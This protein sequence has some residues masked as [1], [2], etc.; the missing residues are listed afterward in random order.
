MIK[1]SKNRDF[2]IAKIKVV[3]VG[4]AGG[5]AVSRM[6]G[7]F[8]RGVDFIAV[9]TDVQDLNFCRTRKKIYIGKNTTKGLGAGMNPD[10][11][12]QAAEENRAELAEALK[13]ADMVFITAGF[14]GGTGT[15]AAPIIAELTRDLG[16]LTVAVITKPFGFEGAQRV[17]IAQEGLL[18]LQDN[19]DTLI[20]IPNDKIFSIIDKNTPLNKAFGKIDEVLKNAV[21][22]IAELITAPGIINVDFADVK[23]VMQDS[24]SA[25]IGIGVA[26]G[27]ERAA[28]A[29]KMAI[30][31]PLLE[32]SVD[33]AT[34]V[35]FSVSGHRDLKMTEVN[36]VAQLIAE[37]VDRS[38]KIIFGTYNDRNLNKGAIK[39]T[40]VATGFENSLNREIGLL[41]DLFI[42]YPPKSESKAV[43]GSTSLT[44]NPEYRRRVE[45]S[46]TKE[47]KKRLPS[48]IK[49]KR[50]PTLAEGEV[51]V[52][53][54]K[55]VGRKDDEDI[56]DVPTFLRRKR[57]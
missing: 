14:G 38:A 48:N 16:I 11:G 44:I 36:E 53:T 28:N 25:I 39:V 13:G 26:E 6:C 29:A 10:L 12:R 3:G 22:G 27:E 4:G 9:N 37:N 18:K 52:P 24:G 21:M 5:N 34:G 40:L 45:F 57:R 23:T 7:D 30:N 17:R 49:A 50:A 54:A 32:I 33:G 1:K 46:E 56:W 43:D 41:P 31:S 55:R 15:G 35:L 51:G 2:N 8:P 42:S 20:T 19:V 47:E